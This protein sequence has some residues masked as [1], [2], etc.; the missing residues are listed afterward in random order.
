MPRASRRAEGNI[1]HVP[2][3]DVL[4]FIG[5]GWNASQISHAIRGRKL[6]HRGGRVARVL[7]I[8]QGP[9]LNR[10]YSTMRDPPQISVRLWPGKPDVHFGK[11]PTKSM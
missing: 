9:L 6:R 5:A 1:A 11:F 3:D 10:A 4:P 7:V 8:F 2:P